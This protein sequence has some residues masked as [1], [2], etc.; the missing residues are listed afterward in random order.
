MTD[1]NTPRPWRIAEDEN[2]LFCVPWRDAVGIEAPNDP[3]AGS[4]PSLVAWLTRP[5]GEANAALIVRAV[6]AYDDLLIAAKE[7][8]IMLVEIAKLT[9]A[10]PMAE[11]SCVPKLIAAIKKAESS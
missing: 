2:N 3:S 11:G 6:N 1:A 10:N 9:S 8:V 4:V 5:D 7:A